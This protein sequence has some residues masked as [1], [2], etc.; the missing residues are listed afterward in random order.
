MLN[1]S[2]LEPHNPFLNK[3]PL[4]LMFIKSHQDNDMEL[5]RAV[6][7]DKTFFVL[8]IREIEL[9][10]HQTH[11][12]NTLKIVIPNAIQYAAIRW[13]HSLLMHVGITQLSATLRKHFWFPSMTKAIAHFV[14]RCEHCQRYN[15]QTIKY[16]HVPPKQI[17]HLD[18][19]E[20]LSGHDRSMKN[21][22]Q[23]F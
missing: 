16:G 2:L 19:W 13:M 20:E 8:T 10:H 3:N 23:R 21:N 17:R 1:L 15:K 4:D 5:Q 6:Q 14:Q 11:E 12:S 7:E 22:H 9:I 18:P